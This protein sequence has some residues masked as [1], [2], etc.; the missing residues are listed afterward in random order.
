MFLKSLTLRGFKSFADKTV[1][2]FEPG[3]TVIV[4]PNGSGKSN[5]VDAIAWVLGEQGAKSLRGGKMDDVVFAGA[6]G[7]PALGRAQVTLALDNRAGQLSTGEPEVTI[8]RVLYRTGES[9]YAL[10]GRACRLLDISEVLSDAGVGREL[11]TLLGQGQLDVVVHGRP[12][13]RRAVIE[14]AAGV[15]K[16]RRRK[17]RA[18]RKLGALDPQLQ[19]LTDLLGELRRQVGPLERQAATARQAADVQ[20]RL[21]RLRLV[22]AA[23]ELATVMRRADQLRER[24]DQHRSRLTQAEAE[25]EARS[26]QAQALRADS[27]AASTAAAHAR[28]TQHGLAT[29][30]E[31]L[32]GTLALADER[33]R[34]LRDQLDGEPEMAP[35][36]GPVGEAEAL[37]AALDAARSEARA[38]G[39]ALADARTAEHAARAARVEVERQ[40]GA[41]ERAVA[42][43]REHHSRAHGEVAALA[44]ALERESGEAEQLRSTVQ[45][46]RARQAEA[47]AELSQAQAAARE[48]EEAVVACSARRRKA[49][50]VA[51][52]ADAAQ[53]EHVR[54][55]AAVR[56][57]YDAA[58]A[59][60]DALWAAVAATGSW[61]AAQEQRTGG[62]QPGSTTGPADSLLQALGGQLPDAVTVPPALATCLTVAE[63]WET[64]VAAA[65][66]PDATA[67]LATDRVEARRLLRVVPLDGTHRLTLVHAAPGCTPRAQDQLSVR[68]AGAARLL[69]YVT[70]TGGAAAVVAD[71]LSDV[72]VAEDL[73]AAEALA[74]DVPEARIV[75]RLGLLLGPGR[76]EGGAPPAQGALA[77]RRAAEQADAEADAVRG[78]VVEAEE[79]GPSLA[80]AA[81]L[82][83]EAMRAEDREYGEVSARAAAAAAALRRVRGDHDGCERAAEL[84]EARLG[85]LT[86]AR[87]RGNQ[88]LEAARGELAQLEAL[89]V[90]VLPASCDDGAYEQ[91]VVGE[92]SVRERVAELAAQDAA[93]TAQ[94]RAL[95]Q[96]IERLQ[97]AVAAA[98]AERARREHQ[99]SARL[100]AAE[101][102]AEAALLARE[103]LGALD[104]SLAQVRQRGEAAQAAAARGRAAREGADERVRAISS[105]VERLRGASSAEEESLV[106]AQS[107]LEEVALRVLDGWGL[108]PAE[109]ASTW[110]ME[111]KEAREQRKA[112]CL[113][114]ISPPS[115][116]VAVSPPAA[117]SHAAGSQ[118][119]VTGSADVSEAASS[120]LLGRKP[121]GLPPEM[122]TGDLASEDA[123]G[124]VERAAEDH[125]APV[126][127]PSDDPQAT[128][129]SGA[130]DD[131]DPRLLRD[132]ELRREASSAERRLG[133]LGQVNPLALEELQALQE[134]VAY[135]GGQLRDLKDSRRDLL[136]VV[137]A[138]D[139][140]VREVFSSAF[141]AVQTE[142]EATFLQLFPGGEGS[143][144][145]TDPDD[146]LGSGVEISARPAGKR[147][148]RLS[149]LSGGE[150]SLVALAF[151]F[152][153]FR[154]L[155][156]PFYV[157]DEVEAALD[158]ANLRRFLGL[159]TELGTRSQLLV[160]SHQRE[161]MHVA[162]VLYGISMQPGG[163]STVV[164]ERLRETRQPA[165][166]AAEAPPC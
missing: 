84:A 24:V 2:A 63:G 41:H 68:A 33:Y 89:A 114:R 7:R 93:R 156:S 148:R 23:R 164:S 17:D 79:P 67:L 69:D 100:R 122:A 133:V 165:L 166:A 143:L 118:G 47:A 140:R 160:V 18:L 137:R 162:D 53:R 94:C 132:E 30:R 92:R 138:V 19:R 1:L 154:A 101:D 126:P 129:S 124:E 106:L 150:R 48:A 73:D 110:G 5:I 9:E 58:V 119:V 155:P 4:G 22:Q 135:L 46:L 139:D 21:A 121:S 13:D 75:T 157:L 147:V 136:A 115:V 74:A 28:D 87:E 145:L 82:A 128:A 123:R 42:Q 116:S 91:L 77:L 65:L 8:T 111:Y 14:E 72:L 6:P 56:A 85:Q 120:A 34:S 117:T 27:G 98:V 64:A 71:L 11:H 109:A 78:K 50:E 59:R 26:S 60:R 144:E 49:Q 125:D 10:N 141:V 20:Q 32:E 96:Q 44:G 51:A 43:R 99:R 3:V 66:G 151:R 81:H 159:L 130:E 70:A 40:R 83:A 142:F 16:H 112:G 12:E 158:N 95:Q 90:P 31:R 86:Q 54:A 62:R 88:R 35:P 163:V 57:R 146:L 97:A 105:E 152:A 103:A 45:G 153:V 52:A 102:A 161:T 37:G 15:S 149:L 108:Q 29:V 104:R 36:T 39:A 38:L 127:A 61:G 131:D 113:A 25:L 55:L 80:Q 107:R 76:V 134:R